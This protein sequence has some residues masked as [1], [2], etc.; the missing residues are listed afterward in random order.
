MQLNSKNI[1]V[2]FDIVIAR[3][4]SQVAHTY[5]WLHPVVKLQLT[6]LKYDTK[7]KG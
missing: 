5:A 1:P 7:N 2:G 4:G 3:S 6:L